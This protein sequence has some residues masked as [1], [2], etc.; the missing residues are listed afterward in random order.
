MSSSALVPHNRR[1]ICA[2]TLVELLV[3]IAIIGALVALLLPAVQSAREAARRTTC[4]NQ[5]KQLGLAM[6]IYESQ[7][8]ELPIGCVGCR[9]ATSQQLLSWNVSLLPMLEEQAIYDQLDLSLSMFNAANQ[10][11]GSMIVQ[12]FLCPSTPDEKLQSVGY[13]WRER[14]F[15]DYGGLY[16]VEGPGHDA[17]RTATQTLIDSKLGVMLYEA[18]T[19]LAAITDGTSHTAIVGEMLLRRHDGECEWANGH[20]LFAQEK[21]TPI[22]ANSG[23]GND[24]GSPHP[25]GALLAWADGHAGWMSDETDQ[26]ILN[27]ALTRAGNEVQP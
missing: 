27:A 13:F 6:Q 2:F 15:T 3:V 7:Q 14:A 19:T 21:Q 11:G 25:G 18:P 23:L 4:Q 10:V 8:G 22:N 24:L 26:T 12:A 1:S 9:S 17:P 16:G 5:L 20:N